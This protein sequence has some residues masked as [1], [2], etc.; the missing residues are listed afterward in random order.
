MQDSMGNADLSV[1]L[2]G[3]QDY[4]AVALIYNQA[5]AT[6]G[7]TFHE[8]A[9]SADYIQRWV[10][11]FCDR[12]SLLVLVDKDQVLGWGIVKRYSD[13]SGYRFCCETSIY[14]ERTARG[15]GHGSLLQQALLQKAAELDYH[16]IVLKIVASNQGSIRFHEKFGFAIVGIQKEI[17][18][19]HGRWHDVA[20]MQLILPS[21][22]E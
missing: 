5:I 17:G 9:V 4:S 13:R 18:F 15:K 22:P 16:H 19:T 11:G 1:R 21:R 20:I 7:M 3:L 6:G 14:L 10:E 12:E 2:G 8:Q